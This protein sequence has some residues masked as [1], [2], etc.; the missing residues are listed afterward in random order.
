MIFGLLRIITCSIEGLTTE[1][2]SRPGGFLSAGDTKT[3]PRHVMLS[4]AGTE[5][6]ATYL[7]PPNLPTP[8]ASL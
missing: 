8:S 7:T 2:P 5:K 3:A 1:N 4:I 6:D